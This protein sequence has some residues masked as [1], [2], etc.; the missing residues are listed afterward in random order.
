MQSTQTLGRVQEAI[1]SAQREA[2]ASFGD[3]RVLLERFIERPRHI[4]VQVFADTHGN[5]VYLYERDCSMQR[6]HQKVCQCDVR[7]QKQPHL[8]LI[9]F[10]VTRHVNVTI[11]PLQPARHLLE[12]PNRLMWR[13]VNLA[14]LAMLQVI[15]EAPA[16][17]ISEAFR[18]SIGESAVAAAKAVGYVNAGTVEFIVDTDSGE[19]FFMEMNTRLQVQIDFFT[20]ILPC[21]ASSPLPVS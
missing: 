3:D 15:E 1:Q 19:Y 17:N 10:D 7:L 14:S 9:A 20:H 5:A 11:Q 13:E 2:A 21:A 12:F 6:R 16:P 4:E 8:N 18:S